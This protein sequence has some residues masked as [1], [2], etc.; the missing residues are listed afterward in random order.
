MARFFS[1][2]T[3]L[4]ALLLFPPS[5]LALISNN[6]VP[7]D[8]TYPIKRK[9]E[10]FILL[11]ASVH[12]TTKA[13][14]SVEQ[15]NR[16][17]KEV[18]ILLDKGTH[19]SQ[20]INELVAQT[21]AAVVEINLVQDP[22]RKKELIKQLSTSISKYEQ[23]L[24]TAEQ[25]IAKQSPSTDVPMPTSSQTTI[26]D[27]SLS[28]T[29]TTVPAAIA[30][31]KK[32]NVSPSPVSSPSPAPSSTQP[33]T[34]RSPRPNPS[35]TPIG[36]PRAAA[37]PQSK[38]SENPPAVS[39]P[40][41]Q[42]AQTISEA[43][44]ELEKINEQLDQTLDKEQNKKQNGVDLKGRQSKNTKQENHEKK[45]KQGIKIEEVKQETKDNLIQNGKV[46]QQRG[47]KFDNKKEH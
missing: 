38:I 3:L 22:V 25:K 11:V 27:V 39:Q 12:P 37:S 15:S 8:V 41:N 10:D 9:L 2:L 16:R 47:E 44:K 33:E 40:I 6:A 42:E 18:A 46:N 24:Q 31:A 28:P 29:S 20:S 13:W 30:R 17:Y 7:G 34:T 1:V 5:T 45:E 4:V 23:G 36:P 32:S 19:V 21:N 26:T 35:I 43:I 14:F